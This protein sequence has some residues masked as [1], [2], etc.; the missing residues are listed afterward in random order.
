MFISADSTEIEKLEGKTHYWYLAP[1]AAES[2]SLVFV[3]AT[4]V[5]GSGHPFH[6]HPEMDEVIYVLDG[7]MEQWVEQEK[8]ILKTG[9]MA[10]I[11][12]NVVHGCYNESDRDCSFLAILS[13]SKIDGPITVEVADQQPWA[14]LK[15]R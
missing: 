13:P 1:G 3:R 15:A 7:E 2:D 8:K 4:I 10:Y 9:D 12:R 6:K 14:S 11:P 5:P